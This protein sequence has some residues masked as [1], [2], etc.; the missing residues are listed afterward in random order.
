MSVVHSHL[1]RPEGHPSP[2]LP[3]D[4]ESREDL[5]DFEREIARKEKIL[6]EGIRMLQER[7]EELTA[8]VAS[9]QE[10]LEQEREDSLRLR[11]GAMSEAMGHRH[12]SERSEPSLLSRALG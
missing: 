4:G 3:S 2:V 8:E 11:R 10:Q 12:E 9:L 7:V 6:T 1:T 5:S